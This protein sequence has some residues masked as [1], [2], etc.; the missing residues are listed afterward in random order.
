MLEIAAVEVFHGDMR[1]IVAD[2][3]VI[4][5]DDI[6]VIDIRDK[7]VFLQ[8]TLESPDAIRTFGYRLKHFDNDVLIVRFSF[9]QKNRRM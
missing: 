2:A 1:V 9:G 5:F 8:E 4:N 7:F 3:Q 6:R